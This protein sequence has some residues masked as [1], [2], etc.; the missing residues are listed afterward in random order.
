MEF[1]LSNSIEDIFSYF[2]DSSMRAYRISL[3]DYRVDMLDP[4]NVE[5]VKQAPTDVSFIFGD[6]GTNCTIIT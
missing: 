1:I 4:E 2:R 5:Q 6:R 3:E